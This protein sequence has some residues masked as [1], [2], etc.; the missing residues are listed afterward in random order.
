MITTDPDKQLLYGTVFNMPQSTS[1]DILKDREKQLAEIRQRG[2]RNAKGN[3]EKPSGV[4]L[5]SHLGN[6]KGSAEPR[7]MASTHGA[8]V[9]GHDD[10]HQ[11][12]GPSRQLHIRGHTKKM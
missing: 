1:L 2:M 4:Q 11:V 7:K 12:T 5:L 3:Q 10:V 6:K 9:V 8:E